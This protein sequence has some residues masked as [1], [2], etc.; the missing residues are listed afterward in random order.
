VPPGCGGRGWR[1]GGWRWRGCAARRTW[2]AVRALMRARVFGCV[3]PRQ[4]R[5][6]RARTSSAARP[7]R[8]PRTPREPPLRWAACRPVQLAA[9]AGGRPADARLKEPGLLR[10]LASARYGAGPRLARRLPTCPEPLLVASTWRRSGAASR[11]TK[12]DASLALRGHE[13][14]VIDQVRAAKGAGR[15]GMS[16]PRRSGR[17]RQSLGGGGSRVGRAGARCGSRGS[18]GARE[19]RRRRWPLRRS[20]RRHL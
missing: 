9:P 12:R 7:S 13:S 1:E 5:A 10:T 3:W 8:C 19:E 14:G 15:R 16:R 6:C 11:F 2:L 17:E 4:A 18:A 20:S